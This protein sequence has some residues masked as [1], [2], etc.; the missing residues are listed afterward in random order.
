MP[1]L[2]A[3][4]CVLAAVCISPARATPPTLQVGSLLLTRCD[5]GPVGYCGSIERPLDP[6]NPNSGLIT[7]GFEFYPHTDNSQPAAG[8][9]L[10]QEGGPG[11]STTGSGDFYLSIFGPL[12]KTRDVL[13]ID[14][15]G[16]G[17]SD[18]LDCPLL[19]SGA[20][21]FQ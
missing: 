9:L 21:N 8:T 6:T 20:G 17:T 5:P 13:I 10:P 18:A 2:I 1:I 4:A 12:R 15:R 7:I 3:T 16:T 14:K 11:Y 19:Q